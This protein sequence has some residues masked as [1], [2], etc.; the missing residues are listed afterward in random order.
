MPANSD[1]QALPIDLPFRP[2]PV[3]IVGHDDDLK[4]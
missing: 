1:L 3:A 2:W 4:T